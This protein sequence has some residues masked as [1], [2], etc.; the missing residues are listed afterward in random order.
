MH[1]CSLV[2]LAAISYNELIYWVPETLFLPSARGWF[3]LLSD[4]SPH[5]LYLLAAGLLVTRYKYLAAAAQIR[6]THWPGWVLLFPAIALFLWGHYVNAIDH[7]HLSFLL[8]SMSAAFLLFGKAMAKALLLP[9]LILFL[10]TPIPAVIINQIV[11]P[12]QLWTAD[13]TVWLINAIGITAHAA[14]DL[15]YLENS[16]FRVA[17]TCT[18]LGFIKWLTT[19]AIAYV[20]LFPVSRLQ[21]FLLILSAPFIAYTVNLGRVLSLVFNPENS[22]LSAHVLQGIVFFMVGFIILYLVDC[23]LGVLIKKCGP[24]QPCSNKD[25]DNKPRE[26]PEIKHVLFVTTLASALAVSSYTLPVAS[27]PLDTHSGFVL[28]DTIDE[29]TS[30]ARLKRNGVFHGTLQYSS[31]DRHILH[32]IVRDI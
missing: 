18:A 11:F 23:A 6:G 2:V 5:L 20:Y 15:I 19:F 4:S 21:S 29:W 26:Y 16:N 30:I 13:H 28:P 9:V 12:F 31:Y 17:E 8:M 25:A 32:M 10:G 22:A 14:G 1:Y 24:H 7:I 27:P 3:F